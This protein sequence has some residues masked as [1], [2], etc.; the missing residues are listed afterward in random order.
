MVARDGDL[1]LAAV[2]DM[3]FSDRATSS[4]S[5][6]GFKKKQTR[7]Q[8]L[9]ISH[10]VTSLSGTE[11][12]GVAAQ[13]LQIDGTRFVVS[14]TADGDA[15]AG[16]LALISVNGST[17]FNAPV[18]I[19]AESHYRSSSILWG[20]ISNTKDL[21]SLASQA[22]G[23]SADTVGDLLI[24]SGA[25]LT[26]TAV[27]FNIDGQFHTDV[28]GATYL[29][30]AIDM[31][32]Q[33]LIQH[34]DNG[35]IMTDIRSEDMAERVTYNGIVAAGGVN[36]DADSPIIFAGLRHPL[37][38]SAHPAAWVAGDDDGRIN[39]AGV[40]LDEQ[41]DYTDDETDAD[42]EDHWR[43][44]TDWAEDDGTVEKVLSP[45]PTSADGAEYA[46]IAGL[47]GRDTTINDPITLV[48]YEFYDKQQAL[49]PAF[50]ALLTIVV[51]QGLAG[52]AGLAGQ[53]GLVTEA[54]AATATAAATSATV[55]SMGLAV[56]A[57]AASTI[58]GV[59]DGA[60]AGDID[61]GKI[62]GDA[63]FAAVSAGLTAEI[64]LDSFGGDLSDVG[65]ANE[66]AFQAVG[67]G[68][69]ENLTIARLVEAGIDAT[70]T[71]GLSTAV[72]ETDFLDSFGTSM[73][74]SAISLTMADL[75][76]GI[77]DLNLGEGSFA[78]AA[79]HG[80]VGCAAAEALD[81]NCASGAAAA[82]AQSIYAGTLD[83]TAPD[84]SDTAAYAAWQA[85]VADQA[86]L[87]GASVGY[88][89][90]AGLASNVSNGGSIA[91]SGVVNNYL[92]HTEWGAYLDALAAC[93]TDTA[94]LDAT[95]QIY[96]LVSAENTQRMALCG[97]NAE[98][99]QEHY[100]A[101]L[102]VRADAELYAKAQAL[103]GN[104][105][106]EIRALEHADA[107]HVVNPG[108]QWGTNYASYALRACGG[109]TSTGCF[110]AYYDDMKSNW[111]LSGGSD[112]MFGFAIS[113]GIAVT[114]S[115]IAALRT[116]AATPYCMTGLATELAAGALGE[117]QGVMMMTAAVGGSS[118]LV[119]QHGDKIV[120]VM[121]DFGNILKATDQS[122]LG[123]ILLEVPEGGVAYYDDAGRL[124]RGQID[125][126]GGFSR[127]LDNILVDG[128]VPSAKA[129]FD[130]WA[131]N[132]SPEDIQKIWE[133]D[134]YRTRFKDMI[135]QGGDHEWCMCEHYDQFANWGLSVD[136]VRSL[137]TKTS[138]LRWT[139]PDDVPGIGG[140]PGGHISSPDYAPF[141]G[142]TTFHNELSALI[143]SSPNLDS[144]Y[145][146]LPTFAERWKID[147]SLLPSRPN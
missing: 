47:L 130:E 122:F 118:R 107:R 13:N 109:Q 57:A 89:T 97:S 7:D 115:T 25:D 69:G 58:V 147:P 75:Q 34:K 23:A 10:Q 77:G 143:N 141:T 142:S 88:I 116:C 127:T 17:A 114:P 59:I 12:V 146:A 44:N 132:L 136:D 101:M 33:A 6:F 126:L 133:N 92:N 113:A 16:E 129:D 63:A 45:L 15:A 68:F 124:V 112:A 27:D 76:N 71:S 125:E 78:H 128:R 138:E 131:S 4:S 93:G 104:I 54:T 49:S 96:W 64:N 43:D 19:R 73:R 121:D 102:A 60:V 123:R 90:S 46:Y 135:R 139:V 72:Y 39:L 8:V 20:L 134:R 91:Q 74:S 110:A 70:I 61:M 66:S 82:I 95:N 22:Q 144:F 42:E 14:G 31:D 38:D 21:R 26:M 83:D 98:C 119:L 81:G 52:P 108:G 94:C 50:K 111:L 5:F 117:V 140:L 2:A 145:S 48:S 28:A 24:N 30:A 29:L 62:L 120:G 137:S 84:E 85:Q 3:Y 36:F 103:S 99:L 9:D 51:T 100:D 87:I 35:I 40:Y 65:W 105:G 32:Y 41:S 53:L 86:Q 79:L 1:V 106:A 67:F 55:T 37:L 56:N 18:D 80:V 11:I